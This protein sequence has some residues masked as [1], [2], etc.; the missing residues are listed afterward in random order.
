MTIESQSAAPGFAK[1]APNFGKVVALAES[2]AA[3]PFSRDEVNRA[4]LFG[5]SHLAPAE[6]KLLLVYTAFLGREDLLNGEAFVYPSN[7]LICAITNWGPSTLRRHRQALEH[8]GLIIRNLNRANRPANTEAVDLRPLLA[9]I[10]VAQQVAD[11][12]FD[13]HRNYVARV[14]GSD[15]YEHESSARAPGTELLIQSQHHQSESVTESAPPAR[16]RSPRAAAKRPLAAHSTEAAAI[17]AS[18]SPNQ[19]AEMCFETKQASGSEFKTRPTISDKQARAEIEK[20]VQLAPELAGYFREVDF[21]TVSLTSL[22]ALA[23]DAVAGLFPERNTASHTWTWAVRRHGWRAILGLVAALADPTVRDRYGFL[24]WISKTSRLDF[25]TNLR[26]ASDALARAAAP[27]EAEAAEPAPTV[28]TESP[29][30][31]AAE[32]WIAI[33]AILAGRLGKSAVNAWLRELRY[34]GVESDTLH[35]TA[36]SAFI[37]DYVYRAHLDEIRRAARA[38]GLAVSRVEITLATS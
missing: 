23:G 37:R 18:V 26:R 6:T 11:A 14:T 30:D 1:R 36:R 32:P 19:R 29:E 2:Y 10:R 24:G 31:A 20:A 13:E 22:T 27:Q 15:V 25:T 7:R 17:K 3:E 35:L 4:I 28:A 38:A 21:S 34:H 16:Y 33:L 8:K 12:V 5:M 9:S